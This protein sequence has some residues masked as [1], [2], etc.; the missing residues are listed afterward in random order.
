[1]SY[2]RAYSI[3]NFQPI[4]VANHSIEGFGE[5]DVPL[6][7]EGFVKSLDLN[8]AGRYTNYSTSGSVVTWKVG[9]TSQITSDIRIRGTISRDIRAPTLQSL[10]NTGSSQQQV[11]LDPLRNNAPTNI[12]TIIGGNPNL[13][14]E[15]ARTYTAAIILTPQ[16]LPGFS[17]SVD[18]YKINIK[19]A[20]TTPIADQV[21]QE[22]A[23]GNQNFCAL[24]RRDPTTNA[25][26]TLLVAPVNAAFE[27]TAG[28]DFQLDY[29]RPALGG[30]IDFSILGNYTTQQ[31]VNALGA[32]RNPL[33]SL[34][35]VYEGFPKFRATIGLGYNQDRFGIQSQVRLIGAAKLNQFWTAADVDDNHVPAIAYVDLRAN[36]YLDPGKKFQAYFA[37]DN[38]L[39]KDPP[40][41]PNDPTAAFAYFF[42]PTRTEIYDFLGRSYRVGVRFRF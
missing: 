27:K 7:K 3:G 39:A 23:A 25:I 41:I 38:L 33:G 13:T 21:L 15:I 24:I 17:A 40:I 5:V 32:I 12:T 37:V 11:V 22:C 6:V 9:L 26:T 35:R 19:D 31:E 16:W 10:F 1:L 28:F 36:Y 18:Y 20:F 8:L 14:P 34:N 30:K 2:A 42:V 4:D 29:V